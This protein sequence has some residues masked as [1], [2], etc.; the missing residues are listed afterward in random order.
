MFGTLAK[1]H[2]WLYVRGIAAIL[3]GVLAI[4]WP[5]I[6]L[7]ALVLLVGA[8]AL[9]DGIA[10]LVLVFRGRHSRTGSVWPLILAA[11]AG[12][13][14]A[15]ITVL[16]PGITAIAL[17]AIFAAWSI[18]RGVF[19]I[20]AAIRLRKEIEGEWLLGLAGA[21]SVAVG[22]LLIAFPGPGL[23]A[24]IWLMAAYAILLGIVYISLGYEL[25][26][27]ERPLRH[28]PAA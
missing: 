23:L 21:L 14:T 7:L 4:I 11:I 28:V 26:H 1:N 10:A 19:D 18:V 8:Y 20:W 12:I 13:G 27:K 16:W 15:I 24:L 17:L 6:T 25:G 22:I 3:F 5:G 9:V 2:R